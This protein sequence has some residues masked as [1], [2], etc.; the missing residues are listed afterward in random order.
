MVEA[1]PVMK[2]QTPIVGS[3]KVSANTVVIGSVVIQEVLN[4]S[5]TTAVEA[6]T[7]NEILAVPISEKSYAPHVGT[8]EIEK[9]MSKVANE[10]ECRE[11]CP[12]FSL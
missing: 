1:S 12:R 4:H 7:Q 2:I 5:E 10:E 9:E 6:T 11:G 8:S 3:N